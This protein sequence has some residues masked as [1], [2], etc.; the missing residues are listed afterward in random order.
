MYDLSGKVAVVTGAGGRRGIGRAIATRLASEGA[1]VLITDIMKAPHPDDEE[2]DWHGIDSVVAE[3]E[4]M[5]RR[6]IG[7]YMDQR[8][9]SQVR[10]VVE[11][12]VP[13]GVIWVM[14]SGVYSARLRPD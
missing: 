3:I 7:M 2:H 10:V 1:D 14:G 11:R 9:V 12:A 8:D 13:G 6:A 5:G 4:G